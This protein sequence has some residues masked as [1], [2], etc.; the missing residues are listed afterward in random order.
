MYV[1]FIKFWTISN[2]L[3][4]LLNVS[5]IPYKACKANKAGKDMLYKDYRKCKWVYVLK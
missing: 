4:D 2:S 3:K 1:Y 5:K